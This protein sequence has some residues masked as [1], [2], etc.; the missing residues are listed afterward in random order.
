MK[1]RTDFVTNSS[2]SSFVLEINIELKNGHILMFDAKGG[3]PE[4]GKIDYFESDAIV[5]VSPKQ[6]ATANS[7]DELIELL[8]NGVVDGYDEKI[9]IFD[10]ANL[11]EDDVWRA[12]DFIEKI[13]DNVKSMDDIKSITI[14]GDEEN[15][16]NYRRRF[17]YDR[18]N[19]KY[20]GIISGCEFE[21][22]GDSG[23]DL[24][25]D[26]SDCEIQYIDE[27]GIEEPTENKADA[28][29]KINGENEF[30][31][32]N[33]KY[34]NHIIKQIL[35]E[36]NYSYDE[37]EDPLNIDGFEEIIPG[38]AGVNTI[39]NLTNTLI[40]LYTNFGTYN[41]GFNEV[42]NKSKKEIENAFVSIEGTSQET[43]NGLLGECGLATGYDFSFEDGKYI[44]EYRTCDGGW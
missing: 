43:Y 10:K 11:N 7:I 25:F 38:Y 13:R 27:S 3:T 12:Y 31:W 24:I 40:S 20:T 8:A 23:G 34:E 33:I 21:K 18:T 2:S 39:E 35:K 17:K 28:Y 44:S 41:D 29:F 42:L 15:Y 16:V 32:F 22:D 9:K 26:T 30:K 37:F 5:E 36:Y 1:I 14:K 6:L 19:G 4:S